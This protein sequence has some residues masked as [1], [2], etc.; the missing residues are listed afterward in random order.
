MTTGTTATIQ[1]RAL[2]LHDLVN[3][4]QYGNSLPPDFMERM[5]THDGQVSLGSGWQALYDVFEGG[6]NMVPIGGESDQL[7]LD[8]EHEN[9]GLEALKLMLGNPARRDE[10]R[11]AIEA[12]EGMRDERIALGL[13]N[14]TWEL[15]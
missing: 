2:M 4:Y 3:K 9:D 14:A 5:K 6:S 1:I 15:G 10:V 12:L 13:E 8:A 11:D 7:W